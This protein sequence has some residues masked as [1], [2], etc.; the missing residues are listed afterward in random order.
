[1]YFYYNTGPDG[2]VHYVIQPGDTL[3]QNGNPRSFYKTIND[4]TNEMELR[5]YRPL[6]FETTPEY[7]L[8]IKAAVSIM[9]LYL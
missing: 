6:D 4:R 5:V 3:E 1:M 7:T 9:K 8:T 2:M